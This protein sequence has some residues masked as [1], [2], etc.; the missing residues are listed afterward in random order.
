MLSSGLEESSPKGE[1]FSGKGE[2]FSISKIHCSVKKICALFVLAILMT[3][4]QTIF[5]LAFSEIIY[6]WIAL[7]LQ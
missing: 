1:E 6:Q 5:L 2:E 3:L 4:T 7:K